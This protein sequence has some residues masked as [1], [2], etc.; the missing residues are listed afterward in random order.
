MCLFVLKHSLHVW[1][2]NTGFSEG[3]GKDSVPESCG[4]QI[5]LLA[6]AE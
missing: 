2:L 1:P 6:A 4:F 3:F 5:F